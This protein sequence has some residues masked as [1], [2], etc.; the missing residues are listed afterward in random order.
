MAARSGAA[1]CHNVHGASSDRAREI[2]EV[3]MSCHS[4]LS[5]AAHP[6][7]RSDCTRCHMPRVSTRFTH[8]AVTDHRI[9]RRPEIPSAR[10]PLADVALEGK[11]VGGTLVAWADPPIEA[12]QRDLALANLTVG[13][14]GRIS[15]F[16]R[17]GL[18][19]L[20]TSSPSQ[21]WQ[22]T[23]ALIAACDAIRDQR[24][25]QDAVRVC[26]EAAEQLPES[27]DRAMYLGTALAQAGEVAAAERALNKAI[28]LDPSLKHAYVE[29][30]SLYDRQQ[31]N[32]QLTETA[33]RFLNWNPQNIMFRVLKA[34]IAAKSTTSAGAGAKDQ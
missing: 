24:A 33:D 4:A 3:C 19:L 13:L 17:I 31:K 12:R 15:T 34:M 22:D 10:F 28:A 27:A 11:K 9:Q 14:R 7:L 1:Q 5:K 20:A 32:R 8:V 21:G 26:G 30:W 25:W 18:D 16:K 29:L 6:D 23:G 2:T